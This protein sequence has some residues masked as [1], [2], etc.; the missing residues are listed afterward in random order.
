MVWVAFFALA[1]ALIERARV[2]DD[3]TGSDIP[4]PSASPDGNGVEDSAVPVEVD[5]L[6]GTVI[7]ELRVRCALASSSEISEKVGGVLRSVQPGR[8]FTDGGRERMLYVSDA[9][10]STRWG[11]PIT[12]TGE[13]I[14]FVKIDEARCFDVMELTDVSGVKVDRELDFTESVEE[15]SVMVILE[16]FRGS[17]TL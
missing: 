12:G 6:V 11:L 4:A 14:V 17:C 10:E 15:D 1:L 2:Q 9:I 16:S 13:E 3:R 7:V 8:L 5:I